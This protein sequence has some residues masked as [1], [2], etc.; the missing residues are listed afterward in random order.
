MRHHCILLELLLRRDEPAPLLNA[1]IRLQIRSD[2]PLE[3]R[4]RFQTTCQ[5]A[6][7]CQRSHKEAQGCLMKSSLSLINW[8]KGLKSP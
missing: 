6:P 3:Q 5:W 2:S 8:L 4:R 7:A 1:D